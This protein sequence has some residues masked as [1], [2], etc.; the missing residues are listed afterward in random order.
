MFIFG[1]FVCLFRYYFRQQW[2]DLRL[3]F[4]P[5]NGKVN[6]IRLLVDVVK[7]I[8][9]PDL[10]FRCVLFLLKCFLCFL[11]SSST[12]S[13]KIWLCRISHGSYL[14]PV[15]FAEMHLK[16]LWTQATCGTQAHWPSSPRMARF[17]LWGKYSTT[18]CFEF[19][20]PCWHSAGC[21]DLAK[22]PFCTFLHR[23]LETTFVCPMNFHRFPMDTQTCPIVVESFGYTMTTLHFS[24]LPG[25][26]EFD[27]SMM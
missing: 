4:Q 25:A 26:V 15:D 16:I 23:S 5:L 24:W 19:Q 13:I 2:I 1:Y 7:Q 14:Q 11:V 18:L 9:L 10:F 3:Q 27:T 22:W 17:G 20:S 12:C 8:W 21:V 6:R